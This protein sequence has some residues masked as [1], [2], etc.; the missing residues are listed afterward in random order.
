MKLHVTELAAFESYRAYLSSQVFRE[1]ISELCTKYGSQRKVAKAVDIDQSQLSRFYNSI[2]LSILV[3]DLL[4]LL[5]SIGRYKVAIERIEPY[6]EY[7]RKSITKAN[8]GKKQPPVSLGSIITKHCEETSIDVLKWLDK[9]E[10]VKRVGGINGVVRLESMGFDENVVT[11]KYQVFNKE[12]KSFVGHVSILPTTFQLNT[13]T[14]YL[15]GLWAGDNTGGGRVGICNK[16][17][18]LIKKSSELL[19]RCF[20]QPQRLLIGNVMDAEFDETNKQ[21]YREQLLPIV[22]KVTFTVNAKCFRGPALAVSSHNALFKRLLDFLKCNLGDMF[23]EV[24]DVNR[25]AFYAGLFD[26]EGNVNNSK[27]GISFRWSAMNQKFVETLM[28]WLKKDGFHPSYDGA[29]I[30]IGHRKETRATEFQLFAKLVMPHLIHPQKQHAA[31][32]L[33]DET[34]GN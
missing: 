2:Q 28:T 26:A 22:G 27:K 30:K 10:Y 16:N 1:L 9:I 4:T 15:F 31:Q 24:S 21:S 14:M 23:A 18:S 25:G 7:R 12:T 19:Q 8:A 33:L 11:A 20:K 5:Q 32:A 3:R 17:W 13:E 6:S 29:N 34:L